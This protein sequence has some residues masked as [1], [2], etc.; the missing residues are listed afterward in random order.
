MI[1][2]CFDGLVAGIQAWS[3]FSTLEMMTG[4]SAASHAFYN[5]EHGTIGNLFQ[6]AEIDEEW[7]GLTAT[8]TMRS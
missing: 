3:F 4:L 8:W 7:D 5:A 1:E 2:F 6:E